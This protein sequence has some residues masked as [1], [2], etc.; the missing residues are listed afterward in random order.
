MVHI[1]SLKRGERLSDP[2]VTCLVGGAFYHH[3]TLP[4]LL[5][6]VRISASGGHL[7][8]GTFCRVG[9]T[10]GWL[11]AVLANTPAGP[12]ASLRAGPAWDWQVPTWPLCSRRGGC[13][14]MSTL[15]GGAPALVGRV[16]GTPTSRCGLTR[17]QAANVH[18]RSLTLGQKRPHI[19]RTALRD[20]HEKSA[21][22]S[23]QPVPKRSLMIP[24]DPLSSVP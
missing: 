8:A 10:E 1:Q 22:L 23:G 21:L 20:N 7:D 3:H 13:P 5:A 19:L 2:E 17:G 6:A 14:G 16:V 4:P 24:G 9:M 12:P 15:L 18:I 11:S